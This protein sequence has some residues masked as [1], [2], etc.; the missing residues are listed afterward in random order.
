MFD[1]RL[2]AGTPAVAVVAIVVVVAVLEEE[3]KTKQGGRCKA[4]TKYISK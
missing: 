1:E 4:E 2:S 3:N